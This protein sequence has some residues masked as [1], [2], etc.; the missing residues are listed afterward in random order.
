LPPADAGGVFIWGQLLIARLS[1]SHFF[2]AFKLEYPMRWFAIL[3]V[4]AIAF[5][6]VASGEE[7]SDALVTLESRA[8]QALSRGQYSLARDLFT[9]VAERVKDDPRRYEAIQEQIRVCVKNIKQA[10]G[11]PTTA[12]HMPI[13]E[14]SDTKSL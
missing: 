7:K 13:Q 11:T 4:C 2:W 14:I 9:R 3:I 12:R 10:T 1:V 6:L 5:P 8:N